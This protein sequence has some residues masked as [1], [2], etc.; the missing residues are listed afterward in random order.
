MDILLCDDPDGCPAHMI[1]PIEGRPVWV[2]DR[3]TS[4]FTDLSPPKEEQFT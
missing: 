1:Q 4:C 2:L 3:P